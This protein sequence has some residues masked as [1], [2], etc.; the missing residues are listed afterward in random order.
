MRSADLSFANLSTYD[1]FSR[2]ANLAGADLRDAI[3]HETNMC[4]ILFNDQTRF[5]D[6]FRVEEFSIYKLR[7]KEYC[8]LEKWDVGGS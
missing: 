3:L 8:R 4:R 2:G 1:N 7:E 5:P 6:R